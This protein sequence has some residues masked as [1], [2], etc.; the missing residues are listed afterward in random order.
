MS[1]QQLQCPRHQLWIVVHDKFQQDSQKLVSGKEFHTERSATDKSRRAVVLIQQCQK[2]RSR[3]LADQSRCCDAMLDFGWQK[4]IGYY[5]AACGCTSWCST[6]MRLV[7][8]HQ[9]SVARCAVSV[10]NVCRKMMFECMKWCILHTSFCRASA[11]A[12]KPIRQFS[13]K[14]LTCSLPQEYVSLH[15]CNS[16]SLIISVRELCC[17]LVTIVTFRIKAS[18]RYNT[19]CMYACI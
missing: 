19:Q 7:H 17:F 13:I 9:T 2:T 18:D 8:V 12:T 6:C 10:N 4:S 16:L 14:V 3:R 1:K 11:S 5:G 15:L